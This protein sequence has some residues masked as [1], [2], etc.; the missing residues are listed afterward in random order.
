MNEE[1]IRRVMALTK[2]VVN[3]NTILSNLDSNEINQRI[4]SLGDKLVKTLMMNKSRFEIVDGSKRD[5]IV[6][7]VLNM[8]YMTLKRAYKEGDKRFWKGTQQHI[9]YDTTG[10]KKNKSFVDALNPWRKD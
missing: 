1:G 7:I 6:E 2:S 4:L 9:S 5:D 10:D 8:G 3:R